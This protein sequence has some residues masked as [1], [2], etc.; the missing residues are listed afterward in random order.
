MAGILSRASDR[1]GRAEGR[2]PTRGRIDLGWESY[3]RSLGGRVSS[4]CIGVRPRLCWGDFGTGARMPESVGCAGD[5]ACDGCA[6]ASSYQSRAVRRSK[7]VPCATLLGMTSCCRTAKETP[8]YWASCPKIGRNRASVVLRFFHF[9]RLASLKP[10]GRPARRRLP[11]KALQVG[12]LL[13]RE[14][15]LVA[16]CHRSMFR[17]APCECPMRRPARR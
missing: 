6:S 8:I 11:G 12:F 10:E 14:L 3:R 13:A 2:G 7:F 5:G 16:A 9:Q 4:A 17:S 15:A 1:V